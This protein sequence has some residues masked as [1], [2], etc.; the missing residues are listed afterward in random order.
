MLTNLPFPATDFS[1][2][3]DKK[4]LHTSDGPYGYRGV[5]VSRRRGLGAGIMRIDICMRDVSV[6]T[7]SLI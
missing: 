2:L 6:V 1:G 3:K 5:R 7:N 4:N